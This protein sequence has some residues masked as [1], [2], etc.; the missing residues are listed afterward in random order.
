MVMVL[1]ELMGTVC[2]HND[3]LYIKKELQFDY[4]NDRNE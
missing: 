2:H 1:A 3:V 4:Q